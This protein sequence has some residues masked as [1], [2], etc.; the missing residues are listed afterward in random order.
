MFPAVPPLSLLTLPCPLPP[1][2]I[3]LYQKA[4]AALAAGGMG[5][6]VG[7]PAD[8]SLIRM[9]ADNTLPIDQRRNYKVSGRG[10]SPPL[11]LPVFFSVVGII[12]AGS[13]ITAPAE[14]R[15]ICWPRTGVEF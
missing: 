7:T 13:G 5:A 1:Q 8:L 12:L 14:S 10:S 2:A 6:L 15:W 3:P 11:S 9:Q 4:L